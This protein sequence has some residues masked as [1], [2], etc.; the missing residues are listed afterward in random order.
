MANPNGI[1]VKMKV[2]FSNLPKEGGPF[3]KLT[4]PPTP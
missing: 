2:R 3:R 4:I 1:G